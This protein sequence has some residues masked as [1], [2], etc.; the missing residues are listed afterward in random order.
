MA[1]ILVV[2]DEASTAESVV[3]YLRAAGHTCMIET[4][5]E[6]VI[7]SLKRDPYDLV[8]LD[9]MLPGVSGFEVCRRIR[10]DTELYT[11]PVLMLSAMRNEEEVRHGLA[12]GAD[13]YLVKPFDS[14][15][16]IRKVDALLQ[17][18][19]PNGTTDPLT[20]LPGAHAIKREVQRRVSRRDPF[21][22]A[23]VELLHLREFGRNAGREGRERAIRRLGR[24]LRQCGERFGPEAFQ[25]GHMGGGYFTCLL[26]AEQA[27]TFC[28]YVRKAWANQLASLYA[29]V[30]QEKL[31]EETAAG[32][33]NGDG[34]LPLD[35]LCCGT[36]TGPGRSHTPHELFEIV[37]HLRHKALESGAGGV[38]FDQR[39]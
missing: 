38:Y 37:A 5:G 26:P 13:D 11:I 23:Y 24:L 31:Y 1:S 35:I 39:T 12:Q 28:E 14:A 33:A 27:R 21:C 10:R 25:V 34:P 3:G 32:T 4:S 29:R 8:V 36:V 20:E 7:E 17:S 6:C 9:V 15:T 19:V 30:G 22:V 2:E 18:V 16:L